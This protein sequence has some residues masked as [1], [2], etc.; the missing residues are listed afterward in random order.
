MQRAAKTRGQY[1]AAWRTV[2]TWALSQGALGQILPMTQKALHAFL[3]DALSFQCTLSV[4]GQLMKSIQALHKQF[5][6]GALLGPDGDYSRYMH[7]FRRFQGR[8]RRP[9]Y[10][11]HRGIVV[12][13]LR[14]QAPQHAACKGGQGRMPDL[15]PVPTRLEGLYYGDSPANHGM[16]PGGGRCGP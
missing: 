1:W 11:I 16:L 8:Q 7:C 5:R 4:V 13:L 3:W 10:P 12:R 14:F 15:L 2:C 9:L 6:L